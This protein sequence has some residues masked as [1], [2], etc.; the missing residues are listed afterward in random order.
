M[1]AQVPVPPPSHRVA[2]ERVRAGITPR[3]L[4]WSQRRS[5]KG[6][7]PR[8]SESGQVHG[9]RR[10]SRVDWPWRSINAST[11]P[12]VFPSSHDEPRVIRNGSLAKTGQET[13]AKV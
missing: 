13:L 12:H 2:E 4:I 10:D 8:V 7:T 9:K 3:S 5:H 6:G 1:G 11:S